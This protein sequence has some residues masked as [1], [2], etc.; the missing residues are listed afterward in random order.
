MDITWEHVLTTTRT[1]RKRLDL[2]RPVPRELLLECVR[3]ATQAP[4]GSNR[5]DWHFVF[6]DDP[7]KKAALAALYREV[8]DNYLA[9]LVKT[10][11]A[12]DVRAARAP[13]LWDSVAYLRDHLHEVPV[14]LIPCIEARL[15]PDDPANRQAAF[16]GSILPAVW[17]FMLAARAHGLGTAWTT[18]H[19]GREREAADLLGIPYE[20]V[21]QA[22]LLPVAYYLG[23]DFQPAARLPAEQVVH[24]GGW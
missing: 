6:V 16:W 2:T 10:Y 15:S 9:R 3:I 22:G 1:V 8:C 7:D 23:D 24:W 5:Q 18:F 21:T 14:F 20:R 12:G 17:S 4:T 19:L 13:Y 11:P